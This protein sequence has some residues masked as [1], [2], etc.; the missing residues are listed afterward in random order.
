MDH[1]ARQHPPRGQARMTGP[2][3]RN[4]LF[5]VSGK[6][7]LVTGGSRGIGQSIAAGFVKAGARVYVCGRKADACDRTA[8]ELS[9]FGECHGIAADVGT[10]AGCRA[11]A[12]QLGR[13]ET[14]LDVL[15]ANAGALW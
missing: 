1:S 2:T 4:E 15:I 3:M 11:L 6:V 14:R 10:V 5:D 7:V 9:A 13:R 8:L 12:E